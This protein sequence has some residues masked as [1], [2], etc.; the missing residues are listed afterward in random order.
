V[1]R[2]EADGGVRAAEAAVD[3]ADLASAHA[4]YAAERDAALPDD[5][6]HRPTGGVAGTREG[7]KCLHAHYAWY[8]AGGDDPVG[9]WVHSQL[10][11]SRPAE[12]E[13]SP[14][15][16]GL[17]AVLD[18]DV[19]SIGLV[20]GPLW[21][22]ATGPRVLIAEVADRDPPSPVS[23]TN[24]IGMVT[25][26]LD[27]V[28]RQHLI[29]QP[30]GWADHALELRGAEAWHLACVERGTDALGPAV[31]I[32]RD[33]VEELFRTLATEP[34]AARLHNPALVATRVDSIVATC[35]ALVAIMR[36]LH[37]STVLVR[38]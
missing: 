2:L 38:R 11:G 15:V 25:D 20:D 32:D 18:D 1:S 8:L 9:R 22:L 5:A 19:I 28:L 37:L 35:C 12:A 29:E 10:A 3:P 33:D 6:R 31:E 7:V 14:V 24:A 21:P 30:E 26:D 16:G 34:R 13:P 23:L 27:D 36:S 4:R 17:A